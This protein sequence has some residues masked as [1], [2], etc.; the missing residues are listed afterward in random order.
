MNG[1]VWV[2][3][4]H[5]QGQIRDVTW[6]LLRKGRQLVEKK[7]GSLSAV[8]LAEDASAM[9][10]ELRLAADKVLVMEDAR[11]T[12][13][14]SDHYQD[15]LV[16]LI[17]EQRPF[18]LLL[19]HTPYGWELAPSLSTALG[20][21]LVSGCS[22]L[23]IEDGSLV[24]S[25]PMY[26]GKLVAECL[27]SPS[28]CSMATFPAGTFAAAEKNVQG[29]VVRL[30]PPHARQHPEKVFVRHV[31]APA[32]E[33]DICQAQRIVAVGRGIR[34]KENI[35]IAEELARC[36]GAVLACSRPVVDAGWLPKERQVGS[37]GKTVRPKLYLALGIS[38]D[39]QHL[40]GMRNAETIVAVNKDPNAP[41]FSV[42]DIGIVD[43]LFKVVPALTSAL[44]AA[45][46][47]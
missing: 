12:H 17:L 9:A 35:Q 23:W 3:V 5:R 2:I 32:G 38:G 46:Q 29:E 36:I 26:G 8:L 42:A 28:W 47:E 1:E 19:G 16:P 34:E 43:D 45:Q 41:I 27:L 20:I 14:H 31:Q 33:V 15:A 10:G 40:M 6:E 37:S 13:F 7:G 25:R 39:F 11:F 44:R 18:L 4:E 24:C 30:D 22:D 21:P